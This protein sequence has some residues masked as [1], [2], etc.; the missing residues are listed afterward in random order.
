MKK[1]IDC[2]LFKVGISQ[3]LNEIPAEYEGLGKIN[4]I[5]NHRRRL[6]H[7]TCLSLLDKMYPGSIYKLRYAN[8]CP[9]LGNNVQISFTH[10][11]GLCAVATSQHN[12]VGIDLQRPYPAIARVRRRFMHP[13]DSVA[14]APF[15]QSLT[16]LWS[17]KEAGLKILLARGIPKSFFKVLCLSIQETKVPESFKDIVRKLWTSSVLVDNDRFVGYTAL[18]HDSQMYLS[19]L[20]KK[21]GR[22]P[23]EG[24]N[25]GTVAGGWGYCKIIPL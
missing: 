4:I 21:P 15:L 24:N 5:S 20:I 17:L 6:Q 9:I 8:G 14:D 3:L 22:P 12:P 25:P 11:D 1:I 13:L 18:L 16:I 10:D 19:I 23:H 2:G 7:A